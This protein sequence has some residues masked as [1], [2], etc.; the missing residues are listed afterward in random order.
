MWDGDAV[1]IDLE[2]G[3]SEV[4]VKVGSGDGQNFFQKNFVFTV[5]AHVAGY[6]HGPNTI[7]KG[8]AGFDGGSSLAGPSS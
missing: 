1:F 6:A 8:L 7:A 3:E 2:G 5:E 4:F